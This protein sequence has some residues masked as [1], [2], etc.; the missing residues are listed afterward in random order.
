M[1][2]GPNPPGCSWHVA[3]ARSPAFQSIAQVPWFMPSVAAW[4]IATSSMSPP[5]TAATAAF[6]SSSRWANSAQYSAAARPK[7]RSYSSSCCIAA[8]L[9]AG[10]GPTEPVLSW[11]AA[12]SDGS[13]ARTAASLSVSL[14]NGETTNL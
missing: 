13:A 10:I 8:A 6:A 4:V 3:T 9:S 5:S 14:M 7:S 11:I 12:L 1:Y 2:S